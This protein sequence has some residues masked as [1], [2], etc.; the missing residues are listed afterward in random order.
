[1]ISH[2]VFLLEN[3]SFFNKRKIKTRENISTTVCKMLKIDSKL[4]YV[5]NNDF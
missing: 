4:T 1:M 5:K 2:Y 3:L